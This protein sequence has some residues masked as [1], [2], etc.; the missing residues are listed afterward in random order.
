MRLSNRNRARSLAGFTLLELVV[1]ACIAAILGGILLNRM[2]FY[3]RM[4]E[5]AAMEQT[6]GIVRS[7]LNLR[8]ASLIAKNQFTKIHDLV[9]ENPMN[10]LAQKPANYAGEYFGDRALESVVSGQW[11]FD[12]KDR[13]LVYLVHN[14]KK[15]VGKKPTSARIRFRTRLVFE[16]NFPGA[17]GQVAG[18]PVEGVVLE[19]IDPH[20]WN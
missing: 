19:Q 12:L 20:V 11:Y 9:D 3:Q 17:R 16:E 2:Q 1:V 4:A 7:A 18:R 10:W 6:V 13:K 8:V 5:K 15:F 14:H